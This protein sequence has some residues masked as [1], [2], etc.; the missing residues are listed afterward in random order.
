MEPTSNNTNA[1]KQTTTTT[2]DNDSA[3]ALIRNKLDNLYKT[4]PDAAE[5]AREAE[6]ASKPLSKH[7]QFMHHLNHSGKSLAEI[8]TEWHAYYGA[9]SDTEKH[10]VW[11]EFYADHNKATHHPKPQKT[12]NTVQATVPQPE[13]AIA[14]R[15][16]PQPQ[17]ALV[18]QIH[19][20]QIP[21][22]PKKRSPKAIQKHIVKKVHTRG[23]MKAKHHFQSLLFGLGMGATVV[24]MLLFTFFNERFIAPF[25]TP[26]RI[27]SATPII[28]DP[29]NNTVSSEPKIIIPK[30]NVEIPVLYN[31]TSIDE[32]AIQEGLAESVVHYPST[33]N[34]GE[35]GNGVIFG[36]SSSNIFSRGK[37]KFAFLQLHELSE[38]DTFYLNKGGK[39]YVYK[40]ISKLIVKPTQIEVINDTHGKAA[41]F[42]LITCDPPGANINRLVI[43][44]EQISPAPDA[45][46][47]GKPQPPTKKEPVVLPGNAESLWHKIVR[48]ISG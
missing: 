13:T 25:V 30:I 36:H 43:T 29:T 42:T 34:P 44:G 23:K 37:A 12:I 31:V 20:H 24:F 8:Q 41:T 9:L 35:L 14:H 32:N 5:E 47:P 22:Q 10:E 15:T 1:P 48:S 16:Q 6:A 28:V 7:Q 2:P 17:T 46:L 18:Q 45:N 39:Q 19:P 11:Q 26:S 21:Q 4:E 38:G 27:V 40:I 3:V 33:S